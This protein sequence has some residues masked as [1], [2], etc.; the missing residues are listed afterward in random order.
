MLK[1][2]FELLPL[3]AAALALPATVAAKRSWTVR[4]LCWH[5]E[6]Q[7]TSLGLSARVLL[8][9]NAELQGALPTD[10]LV[11]D[12]FDSDGQKLRAVC[13]F[14][15]GGIS[16]WP[17]APSTVSCHIVE[18]AW[19]PETL[20]EFF[21][22]PF[23]TTRSA[24]VT[25]HHLTGDADAAEFTF[26]LLLTPAAGD[27]WDTPAP[28]HLAATAVDDASTDADAA[29]AAP[30][31]AS[32]V[33]G[34]ADASPDAE[35]RWQCRLAVVLVS[36]GPTVQAYGLSFHVVSPACEV[37]T[38]TPDHR[39]RRYEARDCLGA[40]HPLLQGLR[41]ALMVRMLLRVKLDSAGSLSDLCGC[42]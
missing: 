42:C 23:A 24:P 30:A 39:S 33:N 12:W 41:T 4:A 19:R 11:S 28:R 16:R 25:V 15:A 35:A 27:G 3:P 14:Q 9:L 34:S 26:R 1:L 38:V 29:V 31:A 22:T 32:L 40:G 21:T 5:I 8:L 6:H 36:G 13:D 2:K 17:L 10:S 18:F 20:A 7:L 37:H